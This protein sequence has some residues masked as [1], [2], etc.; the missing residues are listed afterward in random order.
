MDLGFDGLMIETHIN[1]SQA[2]SDKEQQITPELLERILKL[3]VIRDTSES[4]E[5]LA[6][7][8][9]EID[10]LDDRLLNILSKRMSVAREIGRYKMQ[11]NMQVLQPVRYDKMVT[12]RI[13]Q[14]LGLELDEDFVKQILEAVHEESVRQQ[15]EIIN[16]S[17][18]SQKLN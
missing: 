11:N 16:R 1:P 3:I 8:R 6:D 14:A 15:F 2:L 17:G 9:R 18:L 4:S 10:E 12:S 5:Y 7:L 13:A